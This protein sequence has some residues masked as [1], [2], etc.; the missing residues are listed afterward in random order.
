MN[1]TRETCE[2][3]STAG[4][5]RAALAD[6]TQRLLNRGGWGNPDVLLVG[7][8]DGPVVVKDFSKRSAWVRRCFGRWLLGREARTYQ[9]LQGVPGVPRLLGQVDCEA[10]V[11]E[12]RPGV[13]LSRSLS[14]ALPAG[15]LTELEESIELMH[16]RGVVHLDLRHRSNILAGDDGHPVLL[17]FASAISFDSK[18]LGG[19]IGLACLAWI[20]RRALRKWRDR[21]GQP[22]SESDSIDSGSSA[23]SRGARR[24]M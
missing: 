16:R 1:E 6:S 20:D 2:L 7:T 14:G 5:D 12:Y 21:L 11:L 19:R 15:F 24:P 22:A 4:L 9:R 3:D 23:G 8:D 13:L 17:D 10:L 18:R